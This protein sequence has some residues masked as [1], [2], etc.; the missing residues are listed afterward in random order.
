MCIANSPFNTV[1]A[2]N[3]VIFAKARASKKLEIKKGVFVK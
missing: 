3:L 1:H 2:L